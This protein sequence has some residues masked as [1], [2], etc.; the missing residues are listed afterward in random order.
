MLQPTFRYFYAGPPKYVGADEVVLNILV[1][2]YSQT[3]PLAVRLTLDTR[4]AEEMGT[5]LKLYTRTQGRRL[6]QSMRGFAFIVPYDVRALL[7]N[8][9]AQHSQYANLMTHLKS[10]PA[11]SAFCDASSECGYVVVTPLAMYG[12]SLDKMDMSMRR[13]CSA[14]IRRVL[15]AVFVGGDGDVPYLPSPLTLRNVL[16]SRVADEFRFCVTGFA[17]TKPVD[18]EKK[19]EVEETISSFVRQVTTADSGSGSGSD[20]DS[21]SDS[22]SDVGEQEQP[23]AMAGAAEALVELSSSD[24]G[25][26]SVPHE[27]VKRER[28]DSWPP[29]RWLATSQKRCRRSTSIY[30]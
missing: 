4:I 15:M 11:W 13:Q 7:R 25:A 21:D 22:G 6:V 2:V 30:Q 20:S 24:T 1:P 23:G 29:H 5:H 3:S 9:A 19:H 18:C 12:E 28:R 17:N 27:A 16:W 8:S 10:L 26:F 14:E